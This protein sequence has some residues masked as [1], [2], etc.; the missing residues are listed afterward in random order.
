MT[1]FIDRTKL[2]KR[3][4]E[5]IFYGFYF[6][7]KKSFYGISNEKDKSE[8]L[9]NSLSASILI[10]LYVILYGVVS[11]VFLNR[12][13]FISTS[14]ERLLFVVLF[15]FFVLLLLLYVLSFFKKKR[16]LQIIEVFKKERK[17]QTISLFLCL[18]FLIIP[19]IV[20]LLTPLQS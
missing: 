9:F 20:L 11:Y 3:F 19:F 14:R 7:W 8:T 1:S 12:I 2:M 16:Y 18:L 10:I 4:F 6:V 13:N 5:F 15:V 17:C